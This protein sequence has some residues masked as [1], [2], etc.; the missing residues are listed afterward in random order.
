MSVKYLMLN[1]YDKAFQIWDVIY[2]FFS[3]REVIVSI[4][5][6]MSF[7]GSEDGIQ[8]LVA[9][10]LMDVEAY[11]VNHD[12]SFHYQKMMS[13]CGKTGDFYYDDDKAKTLFENL[14]NSYLKTGYNGQSHFL[15]DSDYLLRNGTHRAALHLY[16]KDYTAKAYVLKRKFSDHDKM[17]EVFKNNLS[18]DV[19]KIIMLKLERIREELIERGVSFCAILPRSL[20]LKD[21]LGIEKVH[22][23][24]SFL[25]Q[26]EFTKELSTLKLLFSPNM[27]Q[28][29]KLVLFTMEEPNYKVVERYLESDIIIMNGRLSETYISPSCYIGKQVYDSLKPYFAKENVI[30]K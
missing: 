30:N 29:Y 1:L 16:L 12:S 22:E 23:A 3:R 27:N 9:S 20:M 6:L 4:G 28:P 5:D 13:T 8:I 11:V 10:R 19:F 25:L 7:R 26:K 15:L 21:V 18:V 24:K 2:D 14:I 17:Y